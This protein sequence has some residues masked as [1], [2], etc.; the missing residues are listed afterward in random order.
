MGIWILYIVLLQNFN[1]IKVRLKLALGLL[2]LTLVFDFNSI[3]VRL[4][5]IV[6]GYIISLF[7]IGFVNA[8]LINLIGKMSMGDY[9]FL[10]VLRQPLYLLVLQQVKDLNDAS[11]R[12]VCRL[13]QP[14]RQFFVTRNCLLTS[15]L[16]QVFVCPYYNQFCL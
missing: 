8:K 4:K 10:C 3:K 11:K 6:W 14:H 9:I 1:S 13:K 12:V 5:P 2:L 16:F 7:S 15:S